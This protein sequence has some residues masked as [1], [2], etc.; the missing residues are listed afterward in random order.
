MSDLKVNGRAS[1]G[2]LT[3]EYVD[4]TPK[5]ADAWLKL[6]EGNRPVGRGAVEKYKREIAAGEWQPSNDAIS[7]ST[8]G[9]LLNGQHRLLAITETGRTVVCLVA[10]GLPAASFQTMDAGTARSLRTYLSLQGEKSAAALAAYLTFMVLVDSGRIYRDTR[11]QKVS[12]P[13]AFAYLNENP[14]ARDACLVGVNLTKRLDCAP[15]PLAAAYE[16]I[17]RANGTVVAQRFI[18]ALTTRANEAE[19]SP[20]LALDRRMREGKR[21][22]QNYPTRN[23]V[24]I[25][26]TAFNKWV[27][28]QSVGQLA[29]GPRAGTEFRLPTVVIAPQEEAA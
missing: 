5:M 23:W 25:I 15:T 16:L 20:I 24:Y 4:V 17:R 2:T 26:L 9:V 7:F 11:M 12:V 6:N 13:E 3:A 28:G 19:G 8:E 14:E 22:K 29:I 21:H 18:E 27:L 1:K 10:R